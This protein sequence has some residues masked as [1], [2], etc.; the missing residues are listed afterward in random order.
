MRLHFHRFMLR[1]HEELT[2][3][4]GRENPLDIVADGF[5]AETD[6]LCFDE[7]FVSDITDAMLLATLLQALF[8]RH[9]AGGHVEHPA[10]R[11]VSQRPAAGAFPTGYRFDQRVLRRDER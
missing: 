11:S 10:G 1:V 3:L 4:Q 6:V 8:A 7:F 9:H 2:E 5:K